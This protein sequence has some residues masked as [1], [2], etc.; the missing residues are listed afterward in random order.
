MAGLPGE[1]HGLSG[2]IIVNKEK[3]THNFYIKSCWHTPAA[4]FFAQNTH[5]YL[6]VAPLMLATLQMVLFRMKKNSK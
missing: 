1:L 6:V 4:L 3:H 5:Q 2:G